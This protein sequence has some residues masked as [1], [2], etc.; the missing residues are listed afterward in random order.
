[1]KDSG[2]GDSDK[3]RLGELLRRHR[4]LLKRIKGME[5]VADD[6]GLYVEL[7]NELSVYP[8]LLEA[9]EHEGCE[10]ALALLCGNK[11]TVQSLPERF[12]TYN[13]KYRNGDAL[14]LSD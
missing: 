13:N 12:S 7:L 8:K 9:L 2:I 10:L 14:T 3:E 6:D 11:T 5:K 4:E 1:M